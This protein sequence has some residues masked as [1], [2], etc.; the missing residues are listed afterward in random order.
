MG[1]PEL[2]QLSLI[3]VGVAQ[4]LL[5]L[6]ILRGQGSTEENLLGMQWLSE[7]CPEG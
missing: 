5:L 3:G 2:A 6:P 7:R 4:S 1:A